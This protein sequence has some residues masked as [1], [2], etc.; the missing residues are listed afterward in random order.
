MV[1]HSYELDKNFLVCSRDQG[2]VWFLQ[3]PTACCAERYQFR[4]DASG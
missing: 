2:Y 3:G 4:D 1:G